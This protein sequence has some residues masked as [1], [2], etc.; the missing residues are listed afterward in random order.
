MGRIGRHLKCEIQK[1][2][3]QTIETRL[4]YNQTA[5]TFTPSG[6]DSPPL[7][8]DRIILVSVDGSGKFAAVGVLTV[9]QGAKPGEKILYSR[10]ATG[11][12]KAVLKMLNDGKVTLYA[13]GEIE[14]TAEKDTS[15][16]VNANTSVEIKKNTDVSIEKELTVE[17]K[18]DIKVMTEKIMTL[19]AQVM[20]LTG[21]Q[22]VVN[23]S[24]PAT[25]SGPFCAITHCHFD[26]APHVGP[27]VNGT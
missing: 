4:K 10:S 5:L 20:K 26:G 3:E 2:I 18:E 21:G 16:T 9:N 22:L 17:V 12:V 1:Y 19:E 7:P 13:P 27:S 14:V 6:D 23:G 11:E 24:V 8:E 15:V 25:G